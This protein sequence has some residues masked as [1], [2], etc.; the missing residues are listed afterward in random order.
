[1]N[2]LIRAG[3]W[4]DMAVLFLVMLGARR[5]FRQGLSEELMGLL[6]WLVGL[7]LFGLW[8]VD[9]AHE[10]SRFFGI[11]LVHGELLVVL[12][13]LWGTFWLSSKLEKIWVENGFYFEIATGF[14]RL[15]GMFCGLLKSMCLAF[16]LMAL[17]SFPS[18]TKGDLMR[19]KEYQREWFGTLEFP[20]FGDLQQD[21]IAQS[22]T[23]K[24][25][26]HLLVAFMR[27]PVLISAAN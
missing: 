11:R 16:A 23:G 18:F 26:Q 10:L 3:N 2:H 24:K 21:V 19:S 7:S 13:L 5:G 9:W 6:Q 27:R 14:D 8:H 25:V 4:F 22:Y 12:G 20:T 1:M 17:L 15:L